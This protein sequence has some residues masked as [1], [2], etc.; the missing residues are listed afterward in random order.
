MTFAKELQTF[1]RRHRMSQSDFAEEIWGRYLNTEG[2]RV[3]RG[4]D[5][6]SVWV[7][8]ISE[9]SEKNMRKVVATF[10]KYL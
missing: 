4:R 1:L 6:I 8:G 3:A 9:P 10:V 2:K 7:R 5:R